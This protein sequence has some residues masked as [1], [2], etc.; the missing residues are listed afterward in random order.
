MF[1]SLCYQQQ[2]SI[3]YYHLSMNPLSFRYQCIPDTTVIT[4]L[5]TSL[6]PLTLSSLLYQVVCLFVLEMVSSTVGWIGCFSLTPWAPVVI[7]ILASPSVSRMID[8]NDDDV[9]YMH[10]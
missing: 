7:H 6:S 2:I 9:Q 10:P 8:V 1:Y 5:T 4:S 3:Y